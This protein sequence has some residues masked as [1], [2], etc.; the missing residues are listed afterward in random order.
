RLDYAAEQ[1][2]D[3]EVTLDATAFDA[4]KF[5]TRIAGGNVPDV[6]QMDRRYVTTYAAQG[7]LM[8]LDSCFEAKDVTPHRPLVPERRRRRHVRGCRLRGVAVLP[9]PRDPAEHERAERGGREPD[10]DTSDMDGLLAAIGKIY[11]GSGS[12]PT[13]LGFDPVATGQGG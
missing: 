5:T 13:R 6:V 4:Q 1:L 8:P 7:L 12:T 10:A 11:Q 2:P 3:V 9:A